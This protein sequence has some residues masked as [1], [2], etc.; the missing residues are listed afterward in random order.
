MA[1]LMKNIS[2]KSG[3][4]GDSRNARSATAYILVLYLAVVMLYRENEDSRR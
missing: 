4:V 2:L 1:V 3:I